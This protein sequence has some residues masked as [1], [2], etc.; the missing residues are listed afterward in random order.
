M[1]PF[2]PPISK[3]EAI[4]TTRSPIKLIGRT[5]CFCVG[6]IG[7]LY[8]A[9]PLFMAL[10]G[11]VAGLERAYRSV[12]NSL[13]GPYVPSL[14]IVLVGMA[15]WKGLRQRRRSDYL[16]TPFSR[17]VTGFLV[18]AVFL[19]VGNVLDEPLK[20]VLGAWYSDGHGQLLIVVIEL[21]LAS[22]VGSEIEAYI[23]RQTETKSSEPCHAHEGR[24]SGQSVWSES[25][26]RPR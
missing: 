1:N 10:N 17:I 2:A 19:V 22:V 5:L 15:G 11:Q 13:S 26:A 4:S 16:P 25:S 23:V 14:A 18:F 8:V 7:C 24:E 20:L 3:D 9:G 6:T 21:L 12:W